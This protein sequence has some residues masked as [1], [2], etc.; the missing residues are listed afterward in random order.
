MINVDK[1]TTSMRY[2]LKQERWKSINILFTGKKGADELAF[3]KGKLHCI[4]FVKR[5]KI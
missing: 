4:F 2:A 3:L 5:L 1:L